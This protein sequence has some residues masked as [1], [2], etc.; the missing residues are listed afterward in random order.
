MGIGYGNSSDGICWVTINESLDDV[1]AAKYQTWAFLF[2][3]QI[4]PLGLGFIVILGCYLK[5]YMTLKHLPEEFITAYN[6]N[7]KKLFWYPA[8]LA[9]A[10]L[11]SSLDICLNGGR[12]Q[13]AWAPLAYMHILFGHSLAFINA[14]VYR[15]VSH[16][17]QNESLVTEESSAL[18]D[19]RISFDMVPVMT[20]S[21]QRVIRFDL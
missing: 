6:I 7:A 2:T 10:F 4:F 9:I 3:Y 16:N 1:Y 21:G 15:V 11:P 17:N 8:G 5:Q 20:A 12:N 18:E 19:R 14:L 13:E